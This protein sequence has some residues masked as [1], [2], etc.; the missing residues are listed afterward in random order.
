LA[1]T[2]QSLND[3]FAPG[4]AH[5]GHSRYLSYPAFEISVVGGDY[6]D[7]VLHYPI[8]NAVVCVDTFVV[9][10]QA[11]PALVSGDSQ[12]YPVSSDQLDLDPRTTWSEID[13]LLQVSRAPPCNSCWS[14]YD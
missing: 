1:C 4:H 12:S 5:D 3:V 14:K 13:T 7:F 2:W 9:T 8:H 10:L 6:V 11:F